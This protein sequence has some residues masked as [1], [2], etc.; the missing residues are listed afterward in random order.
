MSKL[1]KRV[2]IAA[3]FCI[4]FGLGLLTAGRALG[5]EMGFWI[6]RTGIYTNQDIR[7][8][9]KENRYVMEKTELDSFD[10]MEV[11]VENNNI[12]VV[13]S[14][15]GHYY[16]E[17]RLYARG[18]EPW[19]RVEN[20]V[21]TVKCVMDQDSSYSYGAGFMIWNT[22]SSFQRGTVKI[23]LPKDSPMKVVKLGNNDAD[24]SYDGPDADTY[25]FTSSYGSMSVSGGKA[26]KVYLNA[27]DGNITCHSMECD[28]LILKNNYGKTDLSD[29]TTNK[30]TIDASDGRISAKRIKA[31]SVSI[32]NTYG[33]LTGELIEADSFYVKMADGNCNLEKADLK[34]AFFENTY[35]TVDV[36]LVGSEK[37]YNYKV[38]TTYGSIRVGGSSF[39]EGEGYQRDNDAERNLT[40]AAED[41]NIVISFTE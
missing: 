4:V 8:R 7:N 35:G 2:L 14:D 11:L 28:E 16:M 12:E 24:L 29:I 20:G 32:E 37:D 1:T 36:E 21:L 18:S 40:V 5:G 38:E 3:G 13:L 41:G 26:G 15:D 25:D 34:E 23:Y 27:S 9:S 19:Y 39:R 6:D 17:Y 31:G 30:L 33:G 10:S 22:G